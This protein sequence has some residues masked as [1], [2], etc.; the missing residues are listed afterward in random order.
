M[1]IKIPKESAFASPLG[2]I[3]KLQGQPICIPKSFIIN[4]EIQ[5]T[6]EYLELEEWFY[7][8]YIQPFGDH[9]EV[10]K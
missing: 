4:R 7:N 1:K 2:V 5:D 3:L 6:S 10:Q 9:I 8:I